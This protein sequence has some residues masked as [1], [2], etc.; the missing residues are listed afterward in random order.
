M[1]RILVVDEPDRGL[2]GIVKRLF[3]PEHSVTVLN[4]AL[5]GLAAVRDGARFGVI[6]CRSAWA[7]S[8]HNALLMLAAEQARN[9]LFVGDMWLRH[10]LSLLPNRF[11]REPFL[12]GELRTGM[13][14]FLRA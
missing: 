1:A 14:A 13:E 4:D 3:E 9:V 11:L 8:F 5:E 7:K 2:G 12:V 6:A 10:E